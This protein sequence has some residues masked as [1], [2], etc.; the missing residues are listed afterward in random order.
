MSNR[1][2][3]ILQGGRAVPDQERVRYV[4][5]TED[6]FKLFLGNRYEHYRANGSTHAHHDGRGLLVFEWMY[7][8]YVAE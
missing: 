2:N 5:N 6:T 8:T 7:R 4:E 1:P 3:V